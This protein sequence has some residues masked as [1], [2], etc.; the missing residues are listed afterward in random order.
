MA[1]SALLDLAE[2]HAS[3]LWAECTDRNLNLTHMR[4]DPG[5]KHRVQKQYA[6]DLDKTTITEALGSVRVRVTL[7]EQ[8]AIFHPN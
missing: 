7:G 5:G 6:L 4:R 8:L 2:R 1:A 3:R